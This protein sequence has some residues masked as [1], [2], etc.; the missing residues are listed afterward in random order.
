MLAWSAWVLA[1]AVLGGLG[2]IAL[3]Q[4]STKPL[5]W[6]GVV[7]GT[8]GVAGFVLLVAGLRGPARGVAE[9]AGSFGIVAAALVGSA[10]LL[11]LGV[12]IARL[13]HRAP[14]MLVVGVHATLAVGGL[15]M[16]AAYIAS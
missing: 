4:V 15:V 3:S 16:L 2:L 11:G 5:R 12:L 9:G 1:A 7:H 6:P 14:S 10:V 13:R 8:L